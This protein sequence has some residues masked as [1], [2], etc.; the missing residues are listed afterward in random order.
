MGEFAIQL[1]VISPER[2]LFSGKVGKVFLP[3]AA[4]PFEVLK[5]HA[6]L[7]SGLVR[8]TIAFTGEDGEGSIEIRSGFVEVAGNKVEVCVEV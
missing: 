8:G 5:D 7:I 3:G 6:P 2:T 4:G 1:E